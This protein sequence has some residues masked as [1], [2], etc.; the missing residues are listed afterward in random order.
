MSKPV[1]F[2]ELLD[3]AFAETYYTSCKMEK[4]D[5]ICCGDTTDEIARV[6]KQIAADYCEAYETACK[7]GGC[8]DFYGG[9]YSY[10]EEELKKKYPPVKKFDVTIDAQVTMY[11]SVFAKDK[12]E[13]E[14]VAQ[15]FV[16]SPGFEEKLRKELHIY[17]VGIGDVVEK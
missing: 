6:C 16:E 17:D 4:E 10:A 12:N 7:I 5:R 14:E 1:E 9:L 2:D 15:K 3:V 13:A 11:Y 8:P